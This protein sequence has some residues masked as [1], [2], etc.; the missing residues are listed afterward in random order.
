MVRQLEI[1][2]TTLRDGEQTSGVAF[3][4]T[5]KLSLA[6]LLIEEVKVNRLEVASARIS[7]GEYEAVEKII[8]W[9]KKIHKHQSTRLTKVNLPTVKRLVNYKYGSLDR[10]MALP[11]GIGE[12]YIPEDKFDMEEYI[13][14]NQELDLL[15]EMIDECLTEKEAFVL[16]MRL[17]EKTLEDISEHFHVSRERIRQIESKALRKLSGKVKRKLG[18]NID[19]KSIMR[20]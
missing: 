16:R 15:Y 10:L 2:D 19:L 13:N 4:S 14:H 6:R 9:S 3:T 7:E 20:A 17:R 11:D 12:R 8:K 18:I 1:M 5:E